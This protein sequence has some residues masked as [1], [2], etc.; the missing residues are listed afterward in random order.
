MNYFIVGDVHGCLHTFQKMIERW[1]P[2]TQ[3]LIQVGDLVDRGNFIVETVAY[4]RELQSKYPE[5]VTFVLGNHEDEVLTVVMSG[6]NEQWFG[7]MGGE[8]ITQYRKAK[9]PIKEDVA[10]FANLP[11][12]Y[13]DVYV[14]VSHAGLSAFA[15]DPYERESLIWHRSEIKFIGKTQVYG[16]TPLFDFIPTF[17]P[18]ARS[19]DIDTA[20][21]YGGRLT[22]LILDDKGIALD[23]IQLDVD[24]RDIKVSYFPKL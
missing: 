8:T 18:V 7:S 14:H 13:E 15:D 16:H 19:Y 9:K 17:N 10:W 22:A 24:P 21:V 23:V 2:N 20:C 5:I 11:L 4:A 1:D 6:E 3:R 12:Y